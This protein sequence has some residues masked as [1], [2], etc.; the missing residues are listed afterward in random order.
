MDLRYDKYNRSREKSRPVRGKGYNYE[1]IPLDGTVLH[2]N[3]YS[4][5]NFKSDP[6]NY[7]QNHPINKQNNDNTSN[8]SQENDYKLAQ[9][10]YINGVGDDSKRLTPQKREDYNSRRY[11]RHAEFDVDRSK[12]FNQSSFTDKGT[13]PNGVGQPRNPQYQNRDFPEYGRK[14]VLHGRDV[15]T[16]T[17]KQRPTIR[18]TNRN[19][20]FNA[21]YI[22][23]SDAF[24]QTGK[25][26]SP[27][28]RSETTNVRYNDY[29]GEIPP[30]L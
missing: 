15:N 4:R 23:H 9:N 12:L 17:I 29:Y 3:S 25:R 18:N 20:Q 2:Y 27:Y 19:N 30:E 6:F 1:R 21:E 16:N 11:R 8:I 14:N 22:H 10:T 26:F 24:N 7:D 13:T 28:N 5:S